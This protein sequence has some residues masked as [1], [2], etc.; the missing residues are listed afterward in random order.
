MVLMRVDG[1]ISRNLSVIAREV[2]ALRALPAG[3]VAQL[4]QQHFLKRGIERSLQVCIEAMVDIANR[5]IA[6]R[7]HA[8]ATSGAES[9]QALERL[10]VIKCAATYAEMV[11]FRNLNAHRYEAIDTAVLRT[12]LERHLADFETFTAEIERY[13]CA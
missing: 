11:K 6:V 1:V 7:Q 2:E 9:V 5:I 8:P 4:E 3:A 13:A 10:G 12:I